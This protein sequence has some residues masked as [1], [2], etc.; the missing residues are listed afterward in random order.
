MH[1]QTKYINKEE[2]FFETCS[3]VLYDY[4]DKLNCD[5]HGYQFNWTIFRNDIDVST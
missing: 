3:D 4:L 5:I 1:L 2:Y